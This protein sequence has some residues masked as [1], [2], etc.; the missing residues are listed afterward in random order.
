MKERYQ[1]FTTL[2]ANINRC[3]K[4]IKIEEMSEFD[5]KSIHVSCLYYLQRDGL[6]TAKQLCEVCEEDKANVSRCVEYLEENGFIKARPKD[7]KRYKTPLEL[8]EKGHVAAEIINS[9][10][11]KI[12]DEAGAGVSDAERETLYRSLGI[13]CDNLQ[14]I[15]DNYDAEE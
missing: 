11:S 9:K 2:I 14:K 15:C 3:I 7:G 13:I 4:R 8:T 6:L 5:L 10:V 12:L 1:Q